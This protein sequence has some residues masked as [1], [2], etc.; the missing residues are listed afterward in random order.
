MK[1]WE[2]WSTTVCQPPGRQ[3]SNVWSSSKFTGNWRRMSSQTSA[4]RGA[5]CDP[6]YTRRSPHRVSEPIR[7][8]PR[9]QPMSHAASGRSSTGLTIVDLAPAVRYKS[10]TDG[11]SS[12][13]IWDGMGKSYLHIQRSSNTIG[14]C[15]KDR[16]QLGSWRPTEPSLASQDSPASTYVQRNCRRKS[17]P[18]LESIAREVS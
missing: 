3:T 8:A 4:W 2:P 18:S 1:A 17:V 11:R 13:S 9:L 12:W 10:W 14:T 7:R 6:R 15:G 16:Q 5:A